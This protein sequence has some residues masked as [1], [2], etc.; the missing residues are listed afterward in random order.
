MCDGPECDKKFGTKAK[1]KAH[2]E[3]AKHTAAA[4]AQDADVSYC[5]LLEHGQY[6]WESDLLLEELPKMAEEQAAKADAQ[7]AAAPAAAPIPVEPVEVGI[8]PVDV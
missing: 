3:K 8:L 4:L 6:K 2:V 7:E 5:P 1:L